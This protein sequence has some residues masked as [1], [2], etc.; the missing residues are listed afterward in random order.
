MVWMRYIRWF[1]WDLDVVM[2]YLDDAQLAYEYSLLEPSQVSVSIIA[3]KHGIT[4]EHAAKI[5]EA[6]RLI[7]QTRKTGGDHW[8]LIGWKLPPCFKELLFSDGQ[9]IFVGI[10]DSL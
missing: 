7:K 8:F 5:C 9:E 1:L 6:S 2:L 3:R 10:V 4:T